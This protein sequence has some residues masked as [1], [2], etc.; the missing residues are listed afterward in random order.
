MWKRKGRGEARGITGTTPET[1]KRYQKPGD[2]HRKKT[3]N[4]GN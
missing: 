4:P 1:T 2:W 3:Q